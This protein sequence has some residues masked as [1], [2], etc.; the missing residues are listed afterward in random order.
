METRLYDPGTIPDCATADWYADRDTAPHI[1]EDL[2]RPRLHLAAQLVA[3]ATRRYHAGSLV[4]IGCG[5][6]GL[7]ELIRPARL[8]AWGYDLQPSN[9]DVAV[10]QRQ[11][12]ARYGDAV[13]DTGCDISAD[14]AVTTEVLEHLLDPHGFLARLADSA[15][16]LVASSPWTETAGDHYPFHLWAWDQPGYAALIDNAGYQVLIHETTGMFQVL[17]AARR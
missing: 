8:T 1:D 11:V 15:P 3:T 4:D 16:L 13:N 6:G 14:I 5:D 10:N 12:D 7:L 9:I 17:L 2:H